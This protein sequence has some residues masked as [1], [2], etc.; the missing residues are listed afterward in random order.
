MRRGAARTLLALSLLTLLGLTLAACSP[1]GLANASAPL[2]GLRVTRDLAYGPDARNVLDLYGPEGGAAHPV[3]LF[4]HGGSW[5]GGSKDEYRFVGESLARAGYLTAVMSYRLA[6]AHRYPDSVQ[7][8]AAALHWLRDHVKAHGGDPDRLYVAGHSAG[9]F[10]ALEV[11]MNARWLAEVGVPIAS[12]RGV[13]GIAGPYDYDFRQFP[14]R[15]AF[16]AGADP[17]DTMPSRHVR[18]DPPPT[19][20]IVAGKDQVVGPENAQRMLAA[21]QA[22]HADARL[23]TLPN[24]D[25]YTVIGALGRNLQFL[26][27]TRKA[28]LDFLA[29]HP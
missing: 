13:V 4:I 27:G 8:A 16:P 14:S 23:V 22:K 10:N 9:A 6:P 26:G 12:I 2:A 21:L 5:T 19:L 11:V 1:L 25:H 29:G 3:I 20:L 17:A 7:D 28:V 15:N 24:L 18:A